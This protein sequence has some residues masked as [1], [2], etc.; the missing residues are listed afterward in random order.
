MC[1]CSVFTVVLEDLPQSFLQIS[2]ISLADGR[3]SS[4]TL[5]AAFSSVFALVCGFIAKSFALMEFLSRKPPHT[6]TE[7]VRRTRRIPSTAGG[8]PGTESDGEFSDATRAFAA[9]CGLP[10]PKAEAMLRSNVEL[11][12]RESQHQRGERLEGA[13]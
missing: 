6:D 1:L 13:V 11:A 3:A 8:V 12:R 5:A 10:L 9:E 7:T 4:P 2:W